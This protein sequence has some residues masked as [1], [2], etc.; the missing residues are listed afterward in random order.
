MLT[1]TGLSAGY[2]SHDVLTNVTFQLEK[3]RNLSI[4]GPNGSGK[5]TLLRALAGLLPY[6][7]SGILE[8]QEISSYKRVALSR[9]IALMEQIQIPTFPYTVG[10]TVLLGR[11]GQ[12]QGGFFSN[13]TVE[14]HQAVQQV[15]EQTRLSAL[16]DTP[17][18][19]L[20]G[21]Q[22]QRVFFAQALVQDPMLILLDEP[23]NHLDLRF[24]TE[25][26]ELLSQWQQQGQRSVIGV[27]H[28]ITM[29]MSLAD[30]IILLNEGELFAYGSVEQVLTR[31]NLEQVYQV[32][33]V[34]HMLSS[35]SQWEKLQ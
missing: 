24:Q 12:S 5:T 32:D 31:E 19:E 10:E 25:L 1:V 4:V 26:L 21:G 23:T 13:W 35:L 34:E 17:I 20:S 22:L 6:S 29:A 30:D 16:E 8:G 27:L 3:G 9:K 11:Y 7:G 33:V 2:D 18:T 14:D 15:L 28:D